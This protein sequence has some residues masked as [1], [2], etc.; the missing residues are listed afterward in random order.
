MQKPT[1]LQQRLTEQIPLFQS[2]P[3][4]LAL[5]TGQG[6]VVATAV[7]SLSLEYRYPLT[8]TVTDDD[9]TRRPRTV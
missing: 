8:L 7:A 1:Q 4:K 5:I 2:A 3:E 9:A 6:Y